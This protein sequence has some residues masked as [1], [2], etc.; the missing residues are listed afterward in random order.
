M[1]NHV[2][3]NVPSFPGSIIGSGIFVSPNFVLASAGSVGLSLVVWTLS[4]VFSV[5]GALCF[6]EL[7]L[8]IRE[9]GAEYAYIKAAFGDLPAFVILWAIFV[10]R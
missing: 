1:A 8:T 6:A 7:G 3:N 5:I 9:S 4:G 10:V 2:T